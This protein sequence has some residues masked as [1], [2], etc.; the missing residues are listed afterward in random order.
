[1]CSYVLMPCTKKKKS[2]EKLIILN[3]MMLT[4]IFN[5][6][7]MW[8]FPVTPMFPIFYQNQLKCVLW[9]LQQTDNQ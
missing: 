8:S 9:I 7:R 1:M 4:H 3:L 6:H 5:V 2:E